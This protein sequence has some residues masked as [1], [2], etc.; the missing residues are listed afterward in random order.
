MGNFE[1]GKD[2]LIGCQ[3]CG[4]YCLMFTYDT[5]KNDQKMEFQLP[6]CEPKP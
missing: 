6:E 4:N 5:N 1:T 3:I 2:E